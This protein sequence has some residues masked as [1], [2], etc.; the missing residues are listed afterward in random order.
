MKHSSAWALLWSLFLCASPLVRAADVTAFVDVNLVPMESAQVLHA[1]TVLVADGRIAAIG[2]ALAVPAGARVID[3][4]GR[5]FLSP[6]L[7]DMHTHSSTRG[8]LAVYLANGVTS[9]LNMGAPSDLA[10][11]LRPRVNEGRIP[12]P[13][14]YAAFRVDGGPRYGDYFVTNAD[15][16]RAVVRMAKTNG[17]DFIKAYND[18]SAESFAALADEG[19]RLQ[20]P[21][22]GHSVGSVGIEKQLA[23]GQLLVAHAE[24]FLYSTFAPPEGASADALPDKDRVQQAIDFVRRDRAFV[25]ADLRTYA[26]ITEQWGRPEV[27]RAMLRAPEVRYLAPAQRIEWRRADYGARKGTLTARLEFLRRFVKAMADAGVPLVAGTDAPTIAGLVPGFSLHDDLAELERAGLSRYQ[28]LGTATR[29]PGELIHRAHPDAESFGTI[30]PGYRADLVL[31]ER[32]PL[33]D[34]ATLR[35]PLGV[36]AGGRWYDKDALRALLDDV[37]REYASAAIGPDR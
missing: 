13:H 8:D 12:G 32:N 16:A 7:A 5:A 23:A 11:Q 6:G 14:I 2:K 28:A 33:D 9:V 37:A 27:P 26:A 18:L 17:Y 15:E 31:S 10:A 36:M 24:E 1:Q 20:V 4:H 30:A 22:V 19:R 34:L 29:T 25:T 35:H 3:G 21:V